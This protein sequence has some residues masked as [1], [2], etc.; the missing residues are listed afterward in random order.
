MRFAR[1]L[2]GIFAAVSFALM[3]FHLMNLPVYP[4]G[5]WIAAPRITKSAAFNVSSLPSDV[6][7]YSWTSLWGRNRPKEG[8]PHKIL[9]ELEVVIQHETRSGLVTLRVTGD[10]EAEV[11]GFIDTICHDFERTYRQSDPINSPVMT[12]DFHSTSDYSESDYY[13]RQKYLWLLGSGFLVSTVITVIL[14]RT[15]SRRT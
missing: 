9:S 14:A 13:W 8:A 10:T 3:V 6:T 15:K 4:I 5:G 11:D 7:D 2:S 12:S 1:I